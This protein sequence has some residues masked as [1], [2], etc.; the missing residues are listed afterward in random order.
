MKRTLL[1]IAMLAFVMSVFGQA[2]LLDGW[3]GTFDQPFD[4]VDNL[5]PWRYF[6]VGGPGTGGFELSDDSYEGAG[7]MK[8]VYPA[9]GVTDMGFDTW[10]PGWDGK[11]AVQ[12][13]CTYIVKFAAYLV[14]GG[15]PILHTTLG[16]FDNSG[17]TPAVVGETSVQ[18]TLG[19][20][21]QEYEHVG[22]AASDAT[23][24]WF[25]FRLLNEDGSRWPAEDNTIM[26]DEVQV[27]ENKDATAI[28]EKA[29]N[30]VASFYPN[31]AGDM[32]RI[33]SETILT[34]VTIFNVAGQMVKEVSENFESINVEDLSTGMYFIKMDAESGS[35]TQK[36]IKK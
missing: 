21:Y 7:A 28:G 18:H 11:I 35:S 15:A 22:V 19:G 24:F 12:P 34:G 32:I 30:L 10:V 5:N 23:S 36:M 29:V 1:G 20:F 27:W 3:N 31:P 33:K 2:N 4:T 25:G 13:D 26:I 8:V 6:D 14:E 9:G 16:W 17:E